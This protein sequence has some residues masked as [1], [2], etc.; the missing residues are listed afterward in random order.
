MLVWGAD[1][2]KVVI[3]SHLIEKLDLDVKPDLELIFNLRA[4]EEIVME[5]PIYV[6]P[7]I[8][9]KLSEISDPLVRF[10]GEA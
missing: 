6:I 3:S 4:V 9:L 5:T 10:A 2:K 8:L 7:D 1:I